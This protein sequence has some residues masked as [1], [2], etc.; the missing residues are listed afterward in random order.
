MYRPLTVYQLLNTKLPV[1]INIYLYLHYRDKNSTGIKQPSL[2][3]VNKLDKKSCTFEYGL[4]K[5][6]SI[7]TSTNVTGSLLVP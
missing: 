2:S 3:C 1:F 5:L 6:D 4:G 7:L